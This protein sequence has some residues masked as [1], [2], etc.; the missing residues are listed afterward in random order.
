MF[1]VHDVNGRDFSNRKVLSRQNLNPSHATLQY[2]KAWSSLRLEIKAEFAGKSL[3]EALF[4][5][6]ID[7]QYDNRLFMEL[8]VQYIKTTSAEY[9]Q[10]MFCP[11]SSLVIQWTIFR[12]ILD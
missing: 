10:N 8:P 5:E 12:H 4:F 9:A 6:S 2:A 7:P 11:F 1:G 3:S